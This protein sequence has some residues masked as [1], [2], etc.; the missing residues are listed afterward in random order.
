MWAGYWWIGAM[1][2]AGLWAGAQAADVRTARDAVG[3]DASYPTWKNDPRFQGDIFTFVRV[4]YHVDGR[5]G[6]GHTRERWAIDFPDSDLNF[7]FRLGQMS[8]MRVNP[9]GR[10]LE[11]TDK[12]LFDHPFIYLVEPGRLTFADDEL[13]VLRRYLLNGGFLMVDDFWGDGEW[14]NF[15]TELKRLFPERKVVDLSME[16]PIFHCVFD[17]KA[18]PQVPGLPWGKNSQATGITWEPN[19]GPGAEQV[20]YRAILDDK[21]RIMVMICHNTDLG[22]GW[23]REGDDEYYFKEFSE[24]KSY[25]MGINIIFYSMTH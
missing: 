10:V 2:G 12:A 19:H 23:E 11:L 3:P 1:V 14:R 6:F 8:S 20:H 4:K 13:I 15:E 21:E 25:P 17:L 7:S 16:H 18:A 5:Y 9:D 24:K 22:D